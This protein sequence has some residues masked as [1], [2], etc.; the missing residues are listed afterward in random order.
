[1]SVTAMVKTRKRVVDLKEIMISLAKQYGYGVRRG[2]TL[3]K[4][5]RPLGFL[6]LV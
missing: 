5:R 1:M 2:C 6:Q 3:G 4:G